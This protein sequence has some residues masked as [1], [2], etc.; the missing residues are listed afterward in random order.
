MGAII[1]TANDQ[2]YAAFMEVWSNRL[3]HY[4]SV[5]GITVVLYDYLLTVTDE[6]CLV[7][8]FWVPQDNCL[9]LFMFLI[10]LLIKFL[11]RCALFGQEPCPSQKSCTTLTDT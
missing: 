7:F 4:H 9:S 8:G 6:V 10:N 3:E 1:T 2:A 5:V 11:D